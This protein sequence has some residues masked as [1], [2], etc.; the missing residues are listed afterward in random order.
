MRTQ[1]VPSVGSAQEDRLGC[2]SFRRKPESS[3]F[4][5]LT[6]RLD[7]DF[8]RHDD[9]VGAQGDGQEEGR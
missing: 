1:G 4:T 2:L 5:A 9:T 6:P 3:A 7:A 8:R